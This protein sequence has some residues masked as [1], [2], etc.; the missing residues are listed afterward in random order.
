MFIAVSVCNGA[1]A[2]AG[3]LNIFVL[4]SSLFLLLPT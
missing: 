2:V 1:I 3:I 4:L